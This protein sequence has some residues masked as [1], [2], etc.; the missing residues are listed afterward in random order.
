[1]LSAHPSARIAL[2]VL[3]CV[4]ATGTVQA[5]EP[6]VLPGK[7]VRINSAGF[8]GVG[9]VTARDENGLTLA[10]E[11]QSAP[12]FVPWNSVSRLETR[13]QLSGGEGALK[14][15]KWGLLITAPLALLVVLAP[16]DPMYEEFPGQVALG[17]VAQGTAIGA[18]VGW[19]RPGGKREPTTLSNRVSITPA[20]GRA[21]YL[22]D[23][24]RF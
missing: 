2:L 5:Q 22:S 7:R 19:L 23:S 12:V 6:S 18:L 4:L 15:A 24:A 20:K 1:M 14:G 11:N 16:G 9:L 17:M 3:L 21:L 10:V 13:R 8:D